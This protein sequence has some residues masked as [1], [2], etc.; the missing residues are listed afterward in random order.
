MAPA[1]TPLLNVDDTVET[2]LAALQ[3]L[4]HAALKMRWRALRGGDPPK[5]LSRPLLIRA[6]AYAMQEQAFGGL[7]P[8]MRRRLQRLGAELQTRG[9]IASVGARARFKLGTRLIRE[10]KGHTHEVTVLENGFNWNGESYRS[11]SAIAKAITGTRWNGHMFFG[12]RSRKS[13][14]AVA[15]STSDYSKVGAIDANVST[16]PRG[17]ARG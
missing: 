11:L 12:L 4:D 3:G 1:E 10:W 8:T 13:P 16:R 2:A 7:N 9:H 5:R 15:G 14:R 6:L 17:G